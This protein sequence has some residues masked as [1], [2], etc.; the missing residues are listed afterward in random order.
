VQDTIA[1]QLRQSAELTN[2]LAD[3]LA[4]DIATAA[5]W[6]TDCYRSR[7]KLLVFGNGGSAADAQHL[8][9]ELTCRL[10]LER[11]PLAAIA[12]TTNTS[13]LTA[14]AND[15]GFETVFSRQVEALARP[16]DVAVAL[17]CSG[18]SA[19]VV[20][21]IERARSIG[22]KTIA[23]TGREGGDLVRLSDLA[24]LVPSTHTQRIQEA[25]MTIGHILCE[26]VEQAVFAG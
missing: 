20:Q 7:G 15:H 12:L 24:L 26:L 1:H 14:Q 4:H 22:L 21:A 16:G 5:E 8:A 2:R 17:S 6:I 18:S 11:P 10:R 19:N 3:E 9:A 25:H 23:L 13:V